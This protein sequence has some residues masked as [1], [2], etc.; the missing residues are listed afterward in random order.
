MS[1]KKADNVCAN[2]IEVICWLIQ[3]NTAY[4]FP[5]WVFLFFALEKYGFVKIW[6]IKTTYVYEK[7]N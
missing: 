3:F 6:H 2:I 1:P 7:R 5:I 4:L